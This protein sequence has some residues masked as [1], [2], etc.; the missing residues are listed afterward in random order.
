MRWYRYRTILWAAM[1]FFL[2]VFHPCDITSW[3]LT[4][5]SRD[6]YQPPVTVIVLDGCF[7]ACMESK[8]LWFYSRKILFVLLCK[9]IISFGD[10]TVIDLLIQSCSFYTTL[11][12]LWYC[13]SEI[14]IIVMFF[15]SFARLQIVNSR[16][17]FIQT[18]LWLY[19]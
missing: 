4:T 12:H 8:S 6:K 3:I 13:Y 14:D 9:I 11:N 18:D 2:C 16:A 7:H 1:V 10:M 17:W 15:Q 5:V 19:I